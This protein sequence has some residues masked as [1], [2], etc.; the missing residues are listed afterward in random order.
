MGKNVILSADCTCDI[1]QE[2]KDQ[3][4]VQFFYNHIQIGDESFIDGV[5]ISSEELYAAWRERGILPKTAAI[6]P[7]EYY[8]YF[9]Q[10]V[11]DGCEIVHLNLGSAL[12]GSY[13]NC[14]I[15]AEQ[16]EHVYPIDSANLSTGIALLV[17]K[18][19]ELIEAGASA[20]EVQAAILNMR[21]KSHAS[22]VLD[23]L[24]FMRAGGRCSAVMAIGANLLRLKPQI[25]VDNKDGARMGVGK[26]YRGSME[27]VLKEYVADQL[28][29]RS[30]LDLDRIFI[31]HSG[32]P[33]S[34]IELVKH[35]IAKYADFKQCYVT[36]AS[37]TISAHCGPRTLGILYMTK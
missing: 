31:T 8:S 6:S 10:W 33:E 27:K 3:F 1:G 29:D 30:D 32:S 4:Q 22:F 19:G 15:A 24:E 5:E 9:E 7:E 23:T 18:A 14:C 11:K 35:E 26:K 16:L 34:D 25:L 20:A 28:K 13:Q 36:K 2:L 37:G 12:S 17:V 21:E